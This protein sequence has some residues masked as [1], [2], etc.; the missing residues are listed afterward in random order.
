MARWVGTAVILLAVLFN[1]VRWPRYYFVSF[2]SSVKTNATYLSHLKDDIAGWNKDLYRGVYHISLTYI[3]IFVVP[4]ATISVMNLLLIRE[5]HRSS[6]K[7]RDLAATASSA[8]KIREEHS[9]NNVTHMLVIII[10]I[11]LVCQ[12]CDFI[13][14][15]KR[16]ILAS[17]QGPLNDRPSKR[18]IH[19][20]RNREESKLDRSHLPDD[21]EINNARYFS[22][23]QCSR[24][25]H[26]FDLRVLDVIVAS[27]GRDGSNE[28][29]NNQ[30]KYQALEI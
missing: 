8:K 29:K 9:R 26:P 7:R 30:R 22:L 6:K 25:T 11:F 1:L 27:E 17:P 28:A 14:A 15:V 21:F 23:D 16:K 3:F 18:T 19:N 4:L 12:L 20:M 10:T 24:S 5:L 13:S 2:Q